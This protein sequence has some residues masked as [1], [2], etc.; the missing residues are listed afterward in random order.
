MALALLTSINS[1]H[2]EASGSNLPPFDQC[3]QDRGTS[4]ILECKK[5]ASIAGTG[6]I[7][8]N[9]DSTDQS[10]NGSNFRF[11]GTGLATEQLG[12]PYDV[13]TG[14]YNWRGDNGCLK[15]EKT[16]KKAQFK[17]EDGVVSEM[18]IL[19]AEGNTIPGTEKSHGDKCD[20]DLT[21]IITGHNR[22]ASAANY[23][24]WVLD[25]KFRSG[26]DEISRCN[27]NQLGVATTYSYVSVSRT[28]LRDG[29]PLGNPTKKSCTLNNSGSY[30]HANTVAKFANKC[31]EGGYWGTPYTTTYSA[32]Y[33]AY[34]TLTDANKGSCAAQAGWNY[35]Q[36]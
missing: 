7:D 29:V 34:P 33:P 32:T 10:L 11:A 1:V 23:T 31:G 22:S 5:I 17:R 35:E 36:F 26:D 6:T 9:S 28:I 14:E 3:L 30:V 24:P 18:P 25:S 27:R 12:D 4:A 2:A 21:F 16:I 15:F 13:G 8:V 20:S 19:D